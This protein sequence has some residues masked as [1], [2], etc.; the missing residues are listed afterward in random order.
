MTGANRLQQTLKAPYIGVSEWTTHQIRAGD[1]LSTELG[2]QLISSQPRHSMRW[3]T[4][5]PEVVPTSRELGISQPAT[6]PR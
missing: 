5:E 1:A 6:R 4:T 2:F 3:R